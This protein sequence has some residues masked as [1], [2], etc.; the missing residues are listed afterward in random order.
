M[1]ARPAVI[2]VRMCLCEPEGDV[3]LYDDNNCGQYVNIPYRVVR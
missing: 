1:P 3:G 2:A